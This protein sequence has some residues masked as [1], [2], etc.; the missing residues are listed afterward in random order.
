MAKKKSWPGLFDDTTLTGLS[1]PAALI[2]EK[3]RRERSPRRHG[4]GEGRTRPVGP[5]GGTSVLRMPTEV[6]G[7]A[8]RRRPGREPLRHPRCALP[9]EA[10]SR[11][12]TGW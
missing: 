1:R 5:G 12:A 2:G 10:T 9:R 4:G 6:G 3:G 8:L 7:P 11:W